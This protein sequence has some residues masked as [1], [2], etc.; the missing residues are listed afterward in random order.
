VTYYVAGGSHDV[1]ESCTTVT[2]KT[3]I[4]GAAVVI[5]TTTTP[6]STQTIYRFDACRDRKRHRLSL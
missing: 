5:E 1:V 3:Y 2:H 4:G 6:T